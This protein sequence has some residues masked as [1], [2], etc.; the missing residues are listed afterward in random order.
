MTP[1][2]GQFTTEQ[3][4]SSLIRL[5]GR[6]LMFDT[7]ADQRKQLA[8]TEARLADQQGDDERHRAEED[9]DLHAVGQRDAA[10]GHLA[11]AEDAWRRHFARGLIDRLASEKSLT[12]A[13]IEAREERSAAE[14]RVSGLITGLESLKA[15]TDLPK[16]AERAESDH[17]SAKQSLEDAKLI[18]RELQVQAGQLRDHV[19]ELRTDATGW[20][21]TSPQDAASAVS[22]SQA[23]LETALGAKAVADESLRITQDELDAVSSGGGGH[24][25][26]AL[27]VLKEAG[28]EAVALMDAT[29]IADHARS[30]WE[31]RLSLYSGA[32]VVDNSLLDQA[33]TAAARLSGAVLVAGSSDGKALPD[34]I[35]ATDARAVAFLQLLARRHDAVG[36]PERAIDSELGVHVI[37]G[38]DPPI[39]GR[40]ARVEAAR[41][42]RQ[43]LTKAALTCEE[44][45]VR[46]RTTVTS[47]EEELARA[48]AATELP[49][50]A[51]KLEAA[52][53]AA[54]DATH[55]IDALAQTEKTA[56]TALIDASARLQNH[57][58]EI[59]TIASKLDLARAA[60]D[61][62]KL[63]EGDVE[64]RLSNLNLTYWR[65]GWGSEEDTA[66]ELL[67]D[68]RRDD[69]TL[70]K[71]ASE[72]LNDA[73]HALDIDRDGKNAPNPD[74]AA[75]ARKRRMIEES[76]E[77]GRAVATLDEV[78]LPLRDWLDS[79]QENDQVTADRIER[80]R[81]R[82][83][84]ELNYLRE[85]CASTRTGL[86][87]IQ[88]AIEQR[89]EQSLSEISD[90]LDRLNRDAGGFGAELKWHSRR[91]QGP[92]DL[93]RWEITPC[94][95]RSHHG[96]M[97]PYDNQTNTAQ[98]KLFTVHL[99]LAALLASS[100]P[101]GRVLI[102][103]EL[104]DSLGI[105]H[106]RDVLEAI[107]ATAR[108]KDI[109]VLGTCQDA[110]LP[111]A[112]AVCGE[113]IYFE[114]PSKA[115]A[116]N[117]PTRMFGF[118]AD[119]S[120]VELTADALRS[121]RPLF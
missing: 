27:R 96:R 77:S 57:E 95:K 100:N 11:E 76:A 43:R 54:A 48:N 70:R 82:R 106:R 25:E 29:V 105:S 92:T 42:A 111:D 34:G 110:V 30:S 83:T 23:A 17:Q 62:A 116:L 65:S 55:S 87:Q 102:L 108:A 22:E 109:T 5:T 64:S 35:K 84:E 103:D 31:P 49:I 19:E 18:E 113:I 20:H 63:R 88:D 13:L 9:V 3:I 56:F 115:Q 81:A 53:R 2:T 15:E 26:L 67:A 94:W 45:V 32:V 93:W 33:L 74:I 7:E 50:R 86:A 21:G 107:A 90:E 61:K 52:E 66:R 37:G 71:I 51:K 89:I 28:I 1:D 119:R 60:H 73:L 99:V 68:D 80:N 112:A 6:A 101:Q 69:A 44:E 4:G 40:Q 14:Q 24:A 39:S 10:R 120:R 121:G 38:F 72:A 41:A 58:T 36:D 91:P 85:E 97:L 75:A 59:K 78:A 46:C 98:E 117:R 12:D 8:E 104:G 79:H 47:S 16:R 114:Y 118:D